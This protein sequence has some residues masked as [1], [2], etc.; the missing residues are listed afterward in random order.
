MPKFEIEFERE[1]IQ[2]DRCK[3]IVE[4]DDLESAYAKGVEMAAEFNS[5]CPDDAET[6]KH[7]CCQD[8]SPAIVKSAPAEAEI[9][10]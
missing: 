6:D 4:A 9:D 7:D 1:V 3:R 10:D 8:W 5:S 2:T